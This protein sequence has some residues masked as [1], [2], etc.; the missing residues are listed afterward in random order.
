MTLAALKS[1]LVL[2]LAASSREAP[3]AEACCEADVDANAGA[4]EDGKEDAGAAHFG[5]GRKVLVEEMKGAWV[6]WN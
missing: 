3:G 1:L 6:Q 4:A 5:L 2:G